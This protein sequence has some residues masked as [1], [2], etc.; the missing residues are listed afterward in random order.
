M[1]LDLYVNKFYKRHILTCEKR[2]VCIGGGAGAGKSYFMAQYFIIL[3][4]LAYNI[5]LLVLRKVSVNVK[6]SVWQLFLDILNDNNIAFKQNK[7]EKILTINNNTIIFSGLDDREKIKSIQRISKIWLEE[8]S[9]FSLNDFNELNRRIRG[10][11]R[12]ELKYKEQIFLTFNP[13]IQKAS[14]IKSKFYDYKDK[15]TYSCLLNFNNN[16]KLNAEYIEQLENIEDSN[17]KKIYYSGQWA[18]LSTKIFSNYNII[19]VEKN[20]Q[21]YDSIKAGIDFGF[22]DPN[23]FVLLGIKDKD[24]YIIYEFYK[25]F[26]TNAEFIKQIELLFI[27]HN[28]NKNDIYIKADSARPE[29]IEEWQGNGFIIEGAKKGKDSIFNGINKIKEHKV[30]IDYECINTRKEFDTYSWKEDKQGN[31]LDKPIDFLNHIIDAIRY[32]I[33]D[34]TRQIEAIENI[35]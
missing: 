33:E 13:D 2:F 1:E 31:V 16:K 15:F 18:E 6:Q 35:F 14:W 22:N 32:A 20:L 19:S 25:S 27:Q 9:E 3:C 30:L 17:L 29:F 5:R 26:L 12:K 8:A 24:I 11:E 10:E 21:F 7:T 23:V 28:L 34:D 4:L